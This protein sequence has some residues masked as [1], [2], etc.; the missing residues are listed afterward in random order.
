MTDKADQTQDQEETY[1][2]I[3]TRAFLVPY[4]TGDEGNFIDKIIKGFNPEKNQFDEYCNRF[5]GAK[6]DSMDGKIFEHDNPEHVETVVKE[7]NTIL[8][9]ETKSVFF[10][11]QN[12]TPFLVHLNIWKRKADPLPNHESYLFFLREVSISD[13]S[14]A[15]ENLAKLYSQV[16]EEERYEKKQFPKHSH[17]VTIDSEQIEPI[18]KMKSSEIMNMSKRDREVEQHPAHDFDPENPLTKNKDIEKPTDWHQ[19]QSS[20]GFYS[21]C[22]KENIDT[23][24]KLKSFVDQKRDIQRK[25]L[26]KQL[27]KSS[28]KK[29]SDE[30]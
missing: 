19:E 7:L 6:I 5:L 24:D 2:E 28:K 17:L 30:E 9:K 3:M 8:K 18:L 26:K 20:M 13:V 11:V 25:K 21:S 14:K 4:T 27:T 23:I 1:G 29:Y 16:P 22:V 10:Q 15:S 12:E